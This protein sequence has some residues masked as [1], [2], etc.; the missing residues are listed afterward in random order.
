MRPV[1]GPGFRKP[2]DE[3]GD[4]EVVGRDPTRS[5]TTRTVCGGRRWRVSSL[6]TQASQLLPT[7]LPREIGTTGDWKVFSL[8]E[9]PLPRRTV[10][11][12]PT[13]ESSSTRAATVTRVVRFTLFREITQGPNRPRRTNTRPEETVAKVGTRP[14]FSRPCV[15]PPS[16]ALPRRQLRA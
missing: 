10:L 8:P 13:P 6:V 9:S 2:S 14:P 1:S 4:M 5:F 7:L 11:N 3:E 12:H 16:P 15:A